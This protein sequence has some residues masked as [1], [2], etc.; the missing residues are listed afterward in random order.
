MWEWFWD[1]R[2]TTGSGFSSPNPITY[3]EIK[4]W[5]EL[6]NIT[7]Y[8]YEVEIIRYLDEVFLTETMKDY[9]KTK[10]TTNQNKA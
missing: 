5:A 1:L 2:K 3:T 10:K 6:K 8:P 7:I 9:E 4:N